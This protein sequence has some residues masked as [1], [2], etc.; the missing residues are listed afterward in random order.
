MKSSKT[1]NAMKAL[2]SSLG[3]PPSPDE[4]VG[5]LTSASDPGATREAEKSVQLNLRVPVAVKQRVRMLAARDGIT[6][7]EVVTRALEMYDDKTGMAG[8]E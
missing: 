7:S 6:N 1:A 3:R 5:T 2:V 8:H 4:V